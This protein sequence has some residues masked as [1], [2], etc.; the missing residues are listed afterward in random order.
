LRTSISASSLVSTGVQGGRLKKV[1]MSA[2]R[3]RSGSQGSQPRST[4]KVSRTSTG[5]QVDEVRGCAVTAAAPP[6]R[7]RRISVIALSIAASIVLT[8]ARCDPQE[9]AALGKSL[10]TVQGVD[11]SL[12][13]NARA[14]KNL[15]G[16]GAEERATQF[17]LL[18]QV[19]QRVLVSA[20]ARM[21]VAV[22]T[23]EGTRAEAADQAAARAIVDRVPPKFS[24]D[25]REVTKEMVKDEAC[26]SLLDQAAPKPV[27]PGESR[28]WTDIVQEAIDRLVERRW[29]RPTD[30]WASFIE[31]TTW[32]DD[33]ES[34]GAQVAN[35]LV[36]GD[37][38]IQQFARPPVQRAALAYARYCY[39]VP[40]LP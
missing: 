25:L 15:T 14:T 4:G 12:L 11:E 37:L 1:P 30:R 24:H 26:Q 35:S 5:P 8:A 18:T 40:K 38:D 13:K 7:S 27:E 10:E 6:L 9:L 32:A 16:L 28:T 29:N 22:L 34:A 36:V 2:P 39:A 19:D 23:A 17:R 20:A 33:V 21:D 3:R 31:W